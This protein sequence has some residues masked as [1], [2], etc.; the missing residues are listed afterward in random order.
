MASR[1]TSVQQP[2]RT[3][4]SHQEG[5]DTTKK[6]YIRIAAALKLSHPDG[7]W[8]VSPTPTQLYRRIVQELA[9]ELS[10]D[11]PRFDRARFREACGL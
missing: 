2:T 4:E 9:D 7:F 3:L 10:R 6:D 11:N 1:L 8:D 5:I